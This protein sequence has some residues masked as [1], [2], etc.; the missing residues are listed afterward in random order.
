MDQLWNSCPLNGGPLLHLC[1]SGLPKFLYISPYWETYWVPV[2]R[3]IFASENRLRLQRTTSMC[4]WSGRGPNRSID[5]FCQGFSGI[6]V[7]ITD[8][9]ISVAV[10]IW[11]SWQF[12]TWSFMAL[13][14]PGNQK[15]AL[16]R[17]LIASCLGCD[18]SWAREMASCCRLFGRSIW[19]P[20]WMMLFSIDSSLKSL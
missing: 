15:C 1:H 19:S 7:G 18:P 9:F 14:I 4:L 20:L 6:G 11:H 13:S 8:A 16:R 12:S 17:R 5:M 3:T 2:E 10:V